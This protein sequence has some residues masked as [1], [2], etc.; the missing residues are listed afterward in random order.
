MAVGRDLGDEVELAL[1]HGGHGAQEFGEALAILFQVAKHVGDG[2]D[3]G[4]AVGGGLATDLAVQ[5]GRQRRQAQARQRRQ[6]WIGLE[7]FLRLRP[8]SVENHQR[9]GRRE[10]SRLDVDG[11]GALETGGTRCPTPA[12]GARPGRR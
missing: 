2:L 6:P 11:V 1:D 10:V 12:L 4:H 9:D 8:S 5:T 7:Q 3:G